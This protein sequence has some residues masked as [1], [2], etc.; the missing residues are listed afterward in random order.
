MWRM[1]DALPRFT[2]HCI[3]E[4]TLTRLEFREVH[5]WNACSVLLYANCTQIVYKFKLITVCLFGICFIGFIVQF[6]KFSRI[7]F[8]LRIWLYYGKVKLNID[9]HF[10][11][12]YSIVL[13]M[14]MVI[15]NFCFRAFEFSNGSVCK[16]R[17]PIPIL[18]GWMHSIVP[19]YSS[20][21][22]PITFEHE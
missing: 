13:V 19:T 2:Q 5:F 17:F 9:E 8:L 14:V 10:T 16:T 11:R 21:K 22:Y 7:W 1:S 6:G 4:S 20:F 3:G 18:L 15:L 12:H